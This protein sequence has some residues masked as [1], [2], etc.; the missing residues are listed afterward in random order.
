MPSSLC[1]PHHEAFALLYDADRDLFA[2]FSAAYRA[3]IPSANLDMDHLWMPK[4]VGDISAT[5]VIVD[6]RHCLP[7]APY[8]NHDKARSHIAAHAR[9]AA[10]Q[11]FKAGASAGILRALDI[12]PANTT[13]HHGLELSFRNLYAHALALGE[14]AELRAAAQQAHCRAGEPKR[15]GL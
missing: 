14:A 15:A 9:I 5:S 6:L 1:F 13:M 4:N 10:T 7:G 12:A 2:D 8:A 11:L 3:N